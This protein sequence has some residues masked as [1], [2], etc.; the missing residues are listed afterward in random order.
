MPFNVK[1]LFFHYNIQQ[2]DVIQYIKN[3]TLVLIFAL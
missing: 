1:G 2:R 3:I